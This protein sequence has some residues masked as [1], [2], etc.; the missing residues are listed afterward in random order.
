MTQ[1]MFGRQTT[2]TPPQQ[3]QPQPATARPDDGPVDLGWVAMVFICFGLLGLLTAFVL[4]WPSETYF[5]SRLTQSA[6][7]LPK[8]AAQPDPELS[9]EEAADAKAHPVLN[10]ALVG[11]FKIRKA[12]EVLFVRVEAD[13]SM[14]GWSFVESEVLDEHKDYLFSFGKELWRETGVDDE[15]PWTEADRDYEMK[16]TIPAKGTYYLNI[17]TQ[18][19]QTPDTLNVKIGSAVGSSLPHLWFGIVVLLIGLV[20]NEVANRTVLR[21]MDRFS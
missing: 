9:A 16:I 1:P 6:P 4:S 10:Y 5:S 11:P 20:L 12:N 13:I 19:D 7:S 15:G 3:P 18:G 2:E 21:L 14:D 8:A 17:K